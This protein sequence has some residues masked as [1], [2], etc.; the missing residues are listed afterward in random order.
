MTTK[1]FHSDFETLIESSSQ[2]TQSF[3]SER[4]MVREESENMF[5]LSCKYYTEFE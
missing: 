2:V 4:V 3:L 1:K 5:S